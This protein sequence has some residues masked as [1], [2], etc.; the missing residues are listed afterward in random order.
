MGIDPPFVVAAPGHPSLDGAVD[1]FIAAQPADAARRLAAACSAIRL[2]AVRDGEVIGVA[3]V[4]LVGPHRAE[5]FV[6]VAAPWRRMGV[7]AALGQAVTAQANARGVP[8]IAVL[9]GVARRPT[10]HVVDNG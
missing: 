1:R 5:L 10:S 4:D 7:A 8:T 6:A 3:R 2:A 9:A